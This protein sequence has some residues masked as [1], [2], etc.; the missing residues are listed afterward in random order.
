MF[1][2]D[3]SALKIEFCEKYERYVVKTPENNFW[4]SL[5]ITSFRIFMMVLQKGKSF[6]NVTVKQSPS[7]VQI[8]RSPNGVKIEFRGKSTSSKIYIN[9]ETVDALNSKKASIQQA[10]DQTVSKCENN[11]ETMLQKP[12][13]DLSKKKTNSKKRP[14]ENSEESDEDVINSKNKT[15]DYD[16][17][18]QTSSPQAK[19]RELGY[20]ES[21]IYFKDDDDETRHSFSPS[22]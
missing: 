13:T 9:R 8:I 7:E 3:N 12:S 18:A 15:S 6:E 2:F 11:S 20:F 1:L 17:D 19:R 4:V 5:N 22:Y 21:Q 14:L 10:F 16:S